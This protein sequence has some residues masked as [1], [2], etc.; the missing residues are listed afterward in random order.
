[1]K[2]TSPFGFRGGARFGILALPVVLFVLC[3][4]G[5]LARLAAA[6]PVRLI[7]DTD[8]GNDVD[9]AL[10]LGVIHALENR[11]ECK[12]LAVTITKDNDLAAPF[13]DAVNTFY[14]RP[15]IPIGV[16][17]HGFTPGPSP[18][19][20]L[21]NQR[22]DGK[23][24]YPHD[25]MSGADAPEATT[26][27]RR[28]LAAQPDGSVVVVQVGLSTDL[29][30][31]LDSKPDQYSPLTG[32]ELVKKKV[33][34]LSLMAGSFQ[35]VNGKEFP[36]YNVVTDLKSSIKLAD[37]WPTPMIYSGFEIGAGI[38]FPSYSIV[39]DFNYVPHHPLA[40]A[41]CHFMPPPHN[42]PC[43]DLT[44]ALEAVRPDRGYFTLSDP[45]R[46]TID[47][48]GITHF[49]KEAGGRQRYLIANEEQ[50]VRVRAVLATL[51]SEP[52]CHCPPQADR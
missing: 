33:R 36:E 13:V 52:P 31:L 42:R 23:L 9:D 2:Q 48:N 41:Y 24:R 51:A 44:S 6:E 39:H 28:V 46:V 49:V 43:W 29:A 7:F 30:R 4:A 1:M 40:E 34:L 32:V 25:L 37:E 27:L 11:G 50:R 17:R 35:P 47:K 16:V 12:L 15:D 8:I 14:G 18:F 26:V 3:A 19:L 21:A 45:G 5:L 38:T 20:P 10:A 22:D